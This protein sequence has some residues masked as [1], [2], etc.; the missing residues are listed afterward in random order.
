[1]NKRQFLITKICM[2]CVLNRHHHHFE[3]ESINKSPAFMWTIGD[4]NIR[5]GQA[6]VYKARNFLPLIPC[7]IMKSGMQAF[8]E[9]KCV[10]NYCYALSWKQPCNCFSSIAMLVMLYYLGIRHIFL[11]VFKIR[12]PPANMA[13]KQLIFPTIFFTCSVP[14]SIELK[15]C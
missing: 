4:G 1:M 5:V 2:K 3:K 8:L 15:I 12:A 7:F 10:V 14:F 9:K 13:C 11:L 6:I